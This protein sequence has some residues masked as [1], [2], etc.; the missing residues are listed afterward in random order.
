MEP[1]YVRG[2]RDFERGRNIGDLGGL[3]LDPKVRDGVR[4]AISAVGQQPVSHAR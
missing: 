3:R 2:L 4:H 1:V